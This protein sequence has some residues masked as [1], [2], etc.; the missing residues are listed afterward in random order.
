MKA[1]DLRK[2]LQNRADTKI[3][4]HSKRF[5]KTGE[6]DYG[7]G[8]EFLGIRVPEQRKIAKRYKALPLEEIQ[9]LL[10]SDYHEERLTAL[11]VLELRFAKASDSDRKAIYEFYMKNL[12][13][14]NNWDLIDSSAPKIP[15]AYLFDKSREVLHTL[16]GSESLWERRI[17]IMATFYFIKQGDLEDTFRIADRLLKDEHDLIHKAVGWMLREAGKKDQSRLEAFLKDRY[18]QM[19][20]TMLRYAIEKFPQ[21]LRQAYLR[22]EI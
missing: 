10:R 20:R 1:S 21:E 12:S 11:F 7:E 9:E 16:A 6:G 2:E 18:Q 4:A 3:A 22:G 15:G 8:D 5:F 14:I 17:A 13:H 19:P